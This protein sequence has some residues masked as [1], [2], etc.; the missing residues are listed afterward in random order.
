MSHNNLSASENTPAW[1]MAHGHIAR[2]FV[3][4]ALALWRK[5][6]IGTGDRL[7][8]SGNRVEEPLG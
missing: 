6:G 1:P 2:F 5:L 8:L 7:A 3:A 4:G